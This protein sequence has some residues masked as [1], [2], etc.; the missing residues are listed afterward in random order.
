MVDM[1]RNKVVKPTLDSLRMQRYSAA[2]AQK[3]ALRHAVIVLGTL[4]EESAHPR[5]A[6][7]SLSAED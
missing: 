1:G 2:S 5:Q 6:P 7:S 3:S 4:H